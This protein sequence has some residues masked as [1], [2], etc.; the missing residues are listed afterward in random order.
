M[1]EIIIQ[2]YHVLDE[3]LTDSNYLELKELNQTIIHQFESEIKAFNQAKEA[4]TQVMSEGGVYHPDFKKVSSMLSESKKNLYETKEMQRY[5]ILEKALQTDINTFLAK[6]TDVI[7]P[8]I[9]TPDVF[10]IIKKG[11]SCHVR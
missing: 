6:L 3:I 10:G 4:Y 1:T 8:H 7:S 9:K 2:A 11:G 5:V